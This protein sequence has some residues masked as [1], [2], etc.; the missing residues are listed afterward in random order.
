MKTK[1]LAILFSS[2]CLLSPAI[3]QQATT[4]HDVQFLHRGDQSLSARLIAIESATKSIDYVTYI[5]NPCDSSTKMIMD[6]LIKKA[7]NT[8]PAVKVRVIIDAFESS[9]PQDRA[10]L[11][12]YFKNNN[13]EL[14]Y[15]NKGLFS[16]GFGRSHIKLMLVDGNE[17]TGSYVSGGRNTSDA[18]FGLSSGVNYLDQDL[19][20]SGSS[21]IK[22]QIA[23]DNLWSKGN[24]KEHNGT[25]N[26]L[27]FQKNCLAKNNR[28]NDVSNYFNAHKLEIINSV[29][30]RTCSKMA[31]FMDDD[32]FRDAGLSDSQNKNE[33]YLNELRLKHKHTTRHFLNFL[34][35][36]TENILAHNQYYLPVFLLDDALER[37]RKDKIKVL[38]FTNLL[39]D[40][41][42]G[43][44]DNMSQLMLHE[45]IKDTKGSQRVAPISSL[46]ALN[47][48]HDLTPLTAAGKWR[49]HTKTA[50]RDNRDIFLGS[51]NMDTL[52]YSGNL[53]SG[54]IVFDC[55]ELTMDVYNELVKLNDVMEDDKKNCTVC[56]KEISKDNL[57]LL[58]GKIL[59]G[60][61]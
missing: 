34:N 56:K 18:Y 30:K 12:T 50:L 26:L 15:Y 28:D 44:N 16:P 53:E 29:P 17:P 61:F 21:V 40:A 35:D 24:I 10:N 52:S 7:K 55:P 27:Q 42:K 5:F 54:M 38:V 14:K 9:E 32:K 4:S 51:Y 49:I 46:G 47:D 6:A 36:T 2:L 20:V 8:K 11:T 19:F 57:D 39:G 59:G 45:A 22:A 41:G 58:W 60:F 3:A 23:F 33:P 37:L 43:L 13:I 1:T 31:F 48:A 25:G